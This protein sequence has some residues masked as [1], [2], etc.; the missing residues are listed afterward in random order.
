LVSHH[1]LFFDS[2]F[3]LD[4]TREP[5]RTASQLI[6]ADL[7]LLVAHTNLDASPEGVSTA[8][9][10]RLGLDRL[11]PLDRRIEDKVKVVLF[12]PAGYEEKIM[13]GLDRLKAGQIGAYRLCTFKT[14]GEG[15]FIPETGSNPYQGE[16]GRPQRASE[17]RLEV[18]VNRAEVTELIKTI[19][20]IH[21]Y[22]EMAYDIY[23]IENPSLNVGIGRLGLYDPPITWETL[24]QRLKHEVEAPSVRVSGDIP[25]TVQKVAVCGGSGGRLIPAALSAGAEILICGEIGYH[26]VVSNQGRGLTLMEIGHYPSEKWVIPILAKA[27]REAGQDEKWGIEV[28]EDREPG[29]PYSQFF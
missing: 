21:P 15:T 4:S 9:A 2:V 25:R 7:S 19:R 24:L 29:D 5:G 1:P 14:R 18:L 3:S 28:F 17:W 23:P 8:L 12:I 22:E 6:R 26:P 13:A 10:H 20:L 16:I 27:L 11:S